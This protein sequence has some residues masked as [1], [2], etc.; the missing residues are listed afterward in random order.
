MEG[1]VA[2]G[3]ENGRQIKKLPE[4]CSI[5]LLCFYEVMHGLWC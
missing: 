2:F 4:R 3:L 1:I 5:E